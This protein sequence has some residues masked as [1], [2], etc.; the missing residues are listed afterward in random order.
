M[1]RWRCEG[2]TDIEWL[3]KD[4][5]DPSSGEPTFHIRLSFSGPD[6]VRHVNAVRL[7]RHQGLT[8]HDVIRSAR[9]IL[10]VWAEETVNPS[11]EGAE[12]CPQ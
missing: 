1:E 12:T 10:I 2:I 7:R 6:R 11:L 8:D 5:H 3:I 9:N 4:T